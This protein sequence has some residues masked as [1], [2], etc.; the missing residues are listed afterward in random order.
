MAMNQVILGK[1]IDSSKI[2]FSTPKMLDNGAKLVYVNYSGGRF[3]VQTPWM[4]VP[5]NMSTNT[6]YDY[7]KHTLTLSFRGMDETASIQSFHDKLLLVD[8]H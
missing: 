6:E 2:S 1:N 4:D 8:T 5:W 7:P 3:T